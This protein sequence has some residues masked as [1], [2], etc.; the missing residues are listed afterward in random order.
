MRKHHQECREKQQCKLA[1]VLYRD[2]PVRRVRHEICH[3]HLQC[4]NQRKQSCEQAKRYCNSAEK[5]YNSCQPKK[6]CKL[7]LAAAEPSEKLLRT[8]LKELGFRDDGKEVMYDGISGK[9]YEAQIL[10]GPCYYQKL[11]HMVANKIQA[12]A[13]GPVTLLTKQPTAGRVKQGGL[14]L[15]E[16]E[17]DCL[18]AHGA[19]LLLK[20]RFSSDKY[21]IPV[22]IRCGLVAI[23]DR[24]K[25]KKYCPVC[26]SNEIEEVE[27]SY[28][29]KLLI[30]ELQSLHIQ[31][32]FELKNKYE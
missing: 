24:V 22:C 4:A 26:G 16:M 3:C 9:R 11:H 12:R 7:G 31:T 14:R 30:E 15:G 28:A 21:S 17:K 1:L 5:F 27:M 20:E 32:Y 10:I 8:M 18:I 25:G 2:E 13:R 23:E 29:F 19:S 6:G